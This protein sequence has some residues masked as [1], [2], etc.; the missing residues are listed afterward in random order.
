MNGGVADGKTHEEI[1]D[2]VNAVNASLEETATTTEES[3]D[4][5]SDDPTGD[6]VTEESGDVPSEG[7]SGA[8]KVASTFLG[9][10][11]ATLML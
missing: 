11:A 1:A 5:T 10:V 7:T 8:T 3:D 4:V 2:E 9:A 6:D